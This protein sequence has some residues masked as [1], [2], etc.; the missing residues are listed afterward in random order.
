MDNIISS[1]PLL[2]RNGI[3]LDAIQAC[4]S[5]FIT[6]RHPRSAVG[7]L[8]NGHWVFVV[9]DGRQNDAEGFTMVELARFMKAFGCTDAL[10]LDGGGSSTMVIKNQLVNSPSGREYGFTRRERPVSNA[11]LIS[12][13]PIDHEVSLKIQAAN[14]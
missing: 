1:T 9:V 2:I 10:N 13:K 5:E 3:I 11:L 7:L 12:A 4:T 6:K 8:E 14:V